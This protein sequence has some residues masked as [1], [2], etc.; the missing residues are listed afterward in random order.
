MPDFFAAQDER[1]LPANVFR[2][3]LLNI[4]KPPAE[5]I[6]PSAM[7]LLKAKIKFVVTPSSVYLLFALNFC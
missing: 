4:Y 1:I 6:L 3:L 2:L 7:L 5:P